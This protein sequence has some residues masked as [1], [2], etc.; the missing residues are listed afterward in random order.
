[1]KQIEKVDLNDDFCSRVWEWTYRSLQAPFFA[2][3]AKKKLFDYL[4]EPKTAFELARDLGFEANAMVRFMEVLSSMGLVVQTGDSYQNL[5][6]TT[7]YLTSQ[8]VMCH[9]P[10]YEGMM[11]TIY[12]ILDNLEDIM[13]DG[14]E[15]HRE[16]FDNSEKIADASF[17][18]R[19]ARSMVGS[20]LH[21]AQLLLP[22]LKAMP[23]W[24]SFAKM[25]DLGGGPGAYCMVYVSEHPAMRG[26][27]FDQ[28]AVTAEAEKIVAE[29]GMQDRIA[30]R[31]GNYLEDADLGSGYDFIWTCA[32]LNFAKG[33]LEPLFRKI[34]RALNPGGVFASYHPGIRGDGRKDWEMVVG[35]APHALIG[36]DMQFKEDEIAQAMLGAGFQSVHSKQVRCIHGEQRLDLARKAE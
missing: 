11:G 3:A 22:H 19:M 27:I 26:V 28:E 8:S 12:R 18:S 29:F 14:A 23:E 35:F 21:Q 32:T 17:W 13:Q 24:G 6:Q 34:R 1:M 4:I 31:A 10:S 33:K 36:M 30:T 7:R 9:L 16:A 5:P 15:K 20:G 25:M 2:L